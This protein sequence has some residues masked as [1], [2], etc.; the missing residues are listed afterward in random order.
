MKL[1]LGDST[2]P[3]CEVRLSLALDA[4]PKLQLFFG[5]HHSDGSSEPVNIADALLR[6]FLDQEITF[7]WQDQDLKLL[8]A[9]FSWDKGPLHYR[10]EGHI[11]SQKRLSVTGLAVPDELLRFFAGR[12]NPTME[13]IYQKDEFAGESAA[14]FLERMLPNTRIFL[15]EEE[16]DPLQ[17]VFER[18]ATIIRPAGQDNFTFL[19]RLVEF[20]RSKDPNYLGW[21]ASNDNRQPL[22]LVSLH[23]CQPVVLDFERWGST[24]RFPANRYAGKD[25]AKDGFWLQTK[26]DTDQPMSLLQQLASTGKQVE[27][28]VRELAVADRDRSQTLLIPGPVVLE[29]RK[30]FCR[31]IRYI[32]SE[33][34]AEKPCPGVSV[35][36]HLTDNPVEQPAGPFLPT[37]IES[38]FKSWPERNPE[39]YVLLNTQKVVGTD[40]LVDPNRSLYA[41]VLSPCSGRDD[42]QGIYVTY[43]PNDKVVFLYRPG[44]EPILL[45]SYQTYNQVFEQAD[46]TINARR[47]VLSTSARE[48]EIDEANGLQMDQ[49]KSTWQYLQPDRSQNQIMIDTQ[50]PSITIQSSPREENNTIRLDGSAKNTVIHCDN[51]LQIQAQEQVSIQSEKIIQADNMEVTSD[52]VKVKKDVAMDS[53]L[54]VAKHFDVG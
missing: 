45:G 22:R 23:H 48:T 49:T 33:E 46:V 2:Y 51:Q 14:S 13:W 47:M 6:R 37:T 42:F 41:R 16:K 53:N 21:T 8:M 17:Q 19:N 10:D 18:F 1:P 36:L 35:R 44:Q 29:D 12:P 26:F 5:R 39:Q 24:G 11:P 52:G 9:G 34:T 7:S 54:K 40:D 32:F 50:V 38:E 28:K 20:I 31:E 15:H 4:V 30:Y 27:H 25:W 43:Q 3:I